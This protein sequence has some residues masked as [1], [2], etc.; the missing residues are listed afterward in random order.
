MTK[1]DFGNWNTK[2]AHREGLA[3]TERGFGG[4]FPV[5]IFQFLFSICELG[6][7]ATCR[8]GKSGDVE[9]ALQMERMAKSLGKRSPSPLGRGG[10]FPAPPVA[11]AYR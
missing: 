9:P 7:G 3:A 8:A 2:A 4:Q 11:A 10:W 1:D 6:R 5:S